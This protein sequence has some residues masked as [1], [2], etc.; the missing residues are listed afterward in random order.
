L[1]FDQFVFARGGDPIAH[2]PDAARGMLGP[3]TPEL[4][5]G[6]RATLRQLLNRP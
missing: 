6:M 4:L 3:P 2:L 1:F 5:G